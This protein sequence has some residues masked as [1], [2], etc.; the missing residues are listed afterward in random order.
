MQGKRSKQPV[1]VDARAE[2]S[3]LMDAVSKI[4]KSIVKFVLCNELS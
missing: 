3:C 1:S 2:E 4:K